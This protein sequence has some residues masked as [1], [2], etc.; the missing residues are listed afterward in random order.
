MSSPSPTPSVR[1]LIVDDDDQLRQTLGKRF[2]KQGMMVTGA[3]SGEEALDK[4][5]SQRCDVALIDLHM[6]GMNGIE[7]LDKLKERQ[8]EVEAIMLTAH[9]SR[10]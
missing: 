3:A 4:L 9:G 6:P 8:P 2:K 10:R 5:A 1:L 7:L